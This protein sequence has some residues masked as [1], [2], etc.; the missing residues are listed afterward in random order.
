MKEAEGNDDP[1]AANAITLDSA[2]TFCGS[3]TAAD[4]DHFA[5]TLPAD[6]KEFG[7]KSAW[8]GLGTPK[9][10]VIVEGVTYGPNDTMP[11]KPGSKYVFKIAESASPIDYVV[12]LGVKR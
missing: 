2:Q 11:F 5:F 12:A 1:A 8:T 9:I 10:S 3:L 4:S 6:A 7:Y